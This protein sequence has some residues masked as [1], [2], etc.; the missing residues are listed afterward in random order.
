MLT[1]FSLREDVY[2]YGSIGSVPRLLIH[3]YDLWIIVIIII[4][5]I[6]IIIIKPI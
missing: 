2:H 4:V 6:I 3:S 1:W 5:I